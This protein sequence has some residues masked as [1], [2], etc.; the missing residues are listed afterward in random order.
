MKGLIKVL[1]L[2]TGLSMLTSCSSTP[3]YAERKQQIDDQVWQCKELCSA[4]SI[5]V[6]RI[7]GLQCMCNNNRQA[8]TAPVIINNIIP[9]APAPV[10]LQSIPTQQPVIVNTTQAPAQAQAYNVDGY[11]VRS[12]NGT[13]ITSS[14]N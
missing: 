10:V 4:G 3:T 1:V 6:A 12:A 5:D 8:N 9:A 7:P 2:S 13:E 14:A 11:K